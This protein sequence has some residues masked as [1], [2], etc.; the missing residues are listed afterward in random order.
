MLEAVRD[1]SKHLLCPYCKCKFLLLDNVVKE[2]ISKGC[3]GCGI[4]ATCP[5]CGKESCAQRDSPAL[6]PRSKSDL[7]NT[8]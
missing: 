7:S 6:K 4:V 1:G 8:I 3:G 2:P 5:V